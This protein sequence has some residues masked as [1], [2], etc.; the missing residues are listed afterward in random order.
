MEGCTWP[1]EDVKR[2]ADG[3]IAELLG[4]GA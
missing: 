4:K 3:D 1:E 2:E